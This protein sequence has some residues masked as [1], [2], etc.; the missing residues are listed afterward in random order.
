[1]PKTDAKTE[2]AALREQ[3][4]QLRIAAEHADDPRARSADIDEADRLDRKAKRVLAADQQRKKE[5]AKIHIAKKE[6]GLDDD[7]YRAI[8]RHYGG[9]DSAATLSSDGRRRVLDQLAARGFTGKPQDK[10]RP[11]KMTPQMQ[12]IEALLADSKLPWRYAVGISKQMYGKQRLEWLTGDE[13]GGVITALV[14]RAEK[15]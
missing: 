12:K 3:A 10:H 9:V 14:M 1:M 2:A 15:R 7:T 4:R 8:L 11:K 5:L 13:L 6:L